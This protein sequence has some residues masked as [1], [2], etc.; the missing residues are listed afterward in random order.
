MAP[1]VPSGLISF[2]YSIRCSSA[3]HSKLA[4]N[5]VGKVARAH[6]DATDSLRAKLSNQDIEKRLAA[7]GGQ[8]LG[9][10]R[11]TERRRVP[12]PPTSRSAGVS[13]KMAIA[14]WE[15]GRILDR[16]VGRQGRAPALRTHCNGS[17]SECHEQRRRRKA[18]S[19][20]SFSRK[21]RGKTRYRVALISGPTSLAQLLTTLLEEREES[22]D[23]WRSSLCM[24]EVR[25]RIR[26]RP[27]H[28][29]EEATVRGL[30]LAC[31]AMACVQAIPAPH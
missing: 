10:G 5:L 20:G 12:I 26:P 18:S 2:E 28:D 11:T 9:C 16:T 27:S 1:A 22:K 4:F 23:R 15:E 8:R 29:I 3:G 13:S 31:P 14:D 25:S 21:G 6:D 30:R 19:R 24:R 17:Q 7:H